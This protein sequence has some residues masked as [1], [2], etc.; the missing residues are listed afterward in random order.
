MYMC[1]DIVGQNIMW[2]EFHVNQ[3]FLSFAIKE[4]GDNMIFRG[5]FCLVTN[6]L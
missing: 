1:L 6:A 3:L 4:M 2:V 5:S